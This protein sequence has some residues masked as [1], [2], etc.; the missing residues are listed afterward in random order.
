MGHRAI[1]RIT[2]QQAGDVA[3]QQ[4]LG[5]HAAALLARE[6]TDIQESIVVIVVDRM[7]GGG[8]DA[9]GGGISP[10]VYAFGKDHAGGS[11]P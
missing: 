11:V 8:D 5:V 6:A 9:K 1:F 4:S 7:D 3:G 2:A 10:V